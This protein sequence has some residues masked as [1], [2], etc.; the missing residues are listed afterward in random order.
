VNRRAKSEIL[1]VLRDRLGRTREQELEA[2]VRE[3]V[4][5][6]RDRWEHP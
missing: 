3:L 4:A 1:E 2:A 6:A 5:I